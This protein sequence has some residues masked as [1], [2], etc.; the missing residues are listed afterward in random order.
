MELSLHT[1]G[2]YE[3]FLLVDVK[4]PILPISQDID[5]RRV[6]ETYIP[7]EF[8]DMTI[9]FNEETLKSWYPK[10]D[11]HRYVSFLN[12]MNYSLTPPEAEVSTSSAC[13]A[14][15]PTLPSFRS[16]LAS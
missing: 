12:T 14:I 9:L 7:A 15:C 10:I 3:L 13:A 4:D 5:I 8:H 2:E 6:M 16:L 1:G 11:E